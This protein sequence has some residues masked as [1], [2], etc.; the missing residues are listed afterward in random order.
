[1]VIVEVSGGVSRRRADR[2]FGDVVIFGGQAEA[3]EGDRKEN[4]HL[5][6]AELSSRQI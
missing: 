3:G 2:V 1:M 6:L 5:G 4:R